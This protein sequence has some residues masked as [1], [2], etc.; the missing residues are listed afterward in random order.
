ME[1]INHVGAADVRLA[2]EPWQIHAACAKPDVDPRVF[3][4]HEVGRRRWFDVAKRVCARCPVR[5]ECLE[6][7]L[8]RREA[9]VWGGLTAS[10]RYRMR[11]VKDRSVPAR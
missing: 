2:Q 9:G 6:V 8:D 11:Q 10:E 3:Y 1:Y 7:A 5:R 4:P